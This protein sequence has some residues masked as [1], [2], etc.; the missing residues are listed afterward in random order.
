MGVDGGPL[1][2]VVAL[3]GPRGASLRLDLSAVDKLWR[4]W[5]LL[6]PLVA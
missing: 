2:C 6:H 1:I 3:I 5:L 4:W